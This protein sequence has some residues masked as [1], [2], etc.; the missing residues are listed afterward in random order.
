MK[1]KVTQKE[2]LREEK[3]KVEKDLEL[4]RQKLKEIKKN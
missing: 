4:A 3:Q 2:M 1:I